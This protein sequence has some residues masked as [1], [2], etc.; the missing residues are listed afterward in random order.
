MKENNEGNGKL[1]MSFAIKSASIS[2]VVLVAICIIMGFYSFSKIR[3]QI[4]ILIETKIL[5]AANSLA[6]FAD[7]DIVGNF[8]PG[9]ESTPEYED[10]LTKAKKVRDD[11]DITY[12]YIVGRDDTGQCVFS[13]DADNEVFI[14]DLYEAKNQYVDAAWSGESSVTKE[15]VS[16]SWG[17]FKVAY[18]PIYNSNKEIVCIVGADYEIS[19]VKEEERAE[20]VRYIL[21]C[22]LILLVVIVV[23]SFVYII[24]YKQI[25][26][27]LLNILTRIKSYSNNINESVKSFETNSIELADSYDTSVNAISEI[28]ATLNETSSMMKMN[29]ENTIKAAEYFKSASKEISEI[30]SEVSELV[31]SISDVKKSSNE[32]TMLVNTITAI[33]KQTK[34]LSINAEVEAARVGESGKGFAVVAQEV[35]LLAYK[36]ETAAQ[37][38]E[39]AIEENVNVTHRAVSNIEQITGVIESINKKI[40]N[41]S[42]IVDELAQTNANQIKGANQ[43]LKSVSIIE[44]SITKNASFIDGVRSQAGDL[45]NATLTLNNQVDSI[46]SV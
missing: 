41:L 25:K 11:I 45:S 14:G 1:I 5:N 18:A 42:L 40:N 33:A 8:Q 30:T 27:V 44:N 21:I 16:T 2:I 32:M 43:I 4:G 22:V 46:E 9:D 12:L 39:R 20:L 6:V 3:T 29:D 31:E 23:F 36:V 38:S 10:L 19:W 17:N 15:T 35:G 37:N 26:Q 34:I 13:F 24:N 28:S 7:G